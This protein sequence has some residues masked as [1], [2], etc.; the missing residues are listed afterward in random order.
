[1]REINWRE[2]SIRDYLHML[3]RRKWALIIPFVLVVGSAVPLMRY[4]TPV[5]QA[6]T[7]LVAEEVSRGNVLRGVA[8][9]PVP[10]GEGFELVQQ[11]MMSRRLLM[12]VADKL[13]LREYLQGK[14]RGEIA[15]TG[16]VSFLRKKWVTLLEKL[17]LKKPREEITDEDIVRYLRDCIS[18]KR[19]S[20]VIEIRVL[21]SNPKL[22]MDIANTLADTYVNDARQ[23]RLSEVSATYD[24]IT[25]QLRIY[26]EKLDQ[27]EKAI[28]EARK[29]GL[30]ASL[31]QENMDLIN[32]L[33]QTDADLVRVEL[34]IRQKSQEISD[35]EN[36][37]Q[38]LKLGVSDPDVIKWRNQVSLLEE[39]L[40]QLLMKY[41]DT[42]PEVR[43]VKGELA[44]AKEML[45]Q[46]EE[47]A[48]SSTQRGLLEKLQAARKE[49]ERLN[50]QKIELSR[51]RNKYQQIMDQLPPENLTISHLLREKQQNEKIYSRLLSRL[52][53][54]NLLTATEMQRM[55]N[56]A[57]ILDRAILPDKPIKPNKK[58]LSIL[59][60]G[61]GLMMGFGLMF[62]LEYFDHSIHSV[63]EAERYFEDVPVLGVIPKLR[64]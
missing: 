10:P 40:N 53:E 55:G 33:T 9:I 59:A 46:A 14:Q 16:F 37:L 35:M 20:R 52:D 32:R 2:L 42:W 29:S 4:M 30:L 48:Y 36:Q 26:K 41:K 25:N 61:L 50:L 47:R 22:T 13:K 5:Y 56:V 19:R 58:K 44:T 60:I 51:K 38:S 57:E 17:K 27:S 63:E 6:S 11:R 54:A 34:D 62:L 23:R 3:N 45:R 21:N 24:F 64:T 7:T 12:Q 18:L 43:K 15:D 8:Q 39:R 28:D 1:V 31:T 49:L